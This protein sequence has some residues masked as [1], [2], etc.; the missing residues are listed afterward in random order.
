[1]QSGQFG[2]VVVNAAFVIATCSVAIAASISAKRFPGIKARGSTVVPQVRDR[3]AKNRIIRS[4]YWCSR[5]YLRAGF[6]TAVVGAGLS[7][8]LK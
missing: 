7:R 2:F 4:E 8:V 5:I 1:L 6:Q 3:F